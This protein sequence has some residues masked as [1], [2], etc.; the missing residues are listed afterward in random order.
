MFTNHSCR[1]HRTRAAAIALVLFAAPAAAQNFNVDVGIALGEPSDSYG[2]AAAQAGRWNQLSVVAP[3][4]TPVALLDL[5]G[6]GTAVSVEFNKLGN[7]NLNFD[8]LLTSG[9]DEALL[10]DFCDVGN[11]GASKVRFRFKN[12]Q[13]GSYDVFVYAWAPD[14]PFNF[15]TN[16]TVVGGAN[17][18]QAC[19]GNDWTGAHVLGETYVTDSLVTTTGQFS[20]MIP[21]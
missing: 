18:I 7:G 3:V 17:G 21:P 14:D 12:L 19:G 6:A 10:D 4:N 20:V 16:V 15:L 8:N 11:T 9:D 1:A 13:P 5:S 2:G